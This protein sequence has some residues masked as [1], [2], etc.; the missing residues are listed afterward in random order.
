MIAQKKKNTFVIVRKIE[1]RS[2]YIIWNTHTHTHTQIRMEA[3]DVNE[4]F[5]KISSTAQYYKLIH[6]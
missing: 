6:N 4:M 3:L 5:R 1:R 2:D